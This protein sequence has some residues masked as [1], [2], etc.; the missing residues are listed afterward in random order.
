[1]RWK[2]WLSRSAQREWCVAGL[3]LS[4]DT[5][6]LVILSGSPQ[7]ANRVCCAELIDAPAGWIRQ[8]LLVEADLLG[9]WL[10]EHIAQKGYDIGS[11]CMGVDDALISSHEF[12]LAAGL[13]DE[14][15][16]FQLS[17]EIQVAIPDA[18]V[19]VDFQLKHPV[20]DDVDSS[21]TELQAYQVDAIPRSHVVQ[22]M[23]MAKAAGLELVVV[24]GLRDARLRLQAHDVL[25]SFSKVEASLALQCEVAFGLALAAWQAGTL[26]FLPYR[27]RA[28]DV[29]RRAWYTGMMVWT[30]SGMVFST[31][32]TWAFSSMAD[33]EQSRRG[34]VAAVTRSLDA[35]SQAFVQAQAL[36]QLA[37]DQR[38]WLQ[39]HQA[40]HQATLQWAHVLNQSTHGLWVSGVTQQNSQWAVQGEA[41]TS[42]H[43]HALMA[44]LTGL[45]IWTR[46]PEMRQLQLLEN[47]PTQGLPVW[48]FRIEAELKGGL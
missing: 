25:K 1:M 17:L 39:T 22:M 6:Q 30:V 47:A 9:R 42:A 44:Q 40:F 28:Q 38:R 34:D 16:A 2:S 37:G 29:L 11:L 26:N 35:A 23:R 7:D 10:G 14:D 27:E 8:G 24:E 45:D 3:D 36:D 5:C 12:V 15:V 21:V 19:C 4:T 31:G 43:A 41:L 13:S 32:L 33:R 18:D 46:S 20:M 48:Q